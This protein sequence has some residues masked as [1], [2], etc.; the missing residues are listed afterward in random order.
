MLFDLPYDVNLKTILWIPVMIYLAIIGTIFMIKSKKAAQE[1]AS[2]KATY[3]AMAVV[4]Y[5]YIAV[6]FFFILSDYERDRPGYP[7]QGDTMLYFQFVTLSYIFAIS[8]FLNL[9]YVFEKYIIK[10]TKFIMTITFMILLVANVIMLFLPNY[11]ATMRY[12]NY[13]PL[14]IEIIILFL[15]YIY[16]VRKT[17]GQLKKN[18]YF[19]LIGLMLMAGGAVLESEFLSATGIVLPYY[20]PI[21]FAI[22]STVFALGQKTL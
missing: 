13:I 18:S 21:L 2:Q 11:V 5:C 12:I 22:G 10:K 8:A 9:I 7:A 14:Y 17:S 19:C 15:L 3:R 1:I 4:F 16:L 6:R 20:S